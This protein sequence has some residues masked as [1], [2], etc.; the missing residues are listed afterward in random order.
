MGKMGTLAE[1]E[2][3]LNGVAAGAPQT[4]SK[5]T[6]PA[7]PIPRIIINH[8]EASRGLAA[9][10]CLPL[11]K[12]K[13]GAGEINDFSILGQ[14]RSQ[15]TR[16]QL[17]A[18]GT[19]MA[20]K[21]WLIL[22]LA[23]LILAGLAC[24]QRKPFLSWYYVRQLV[25]ADKENRATWIKRVADLNQTVL[26]RL[27]SCLEYPEE[28]A[29]DNITAALVCLVELWGPEDERSVALVEEL[30]QNLLRYSQA[31][32]Q[33]SLQIPAVLLRLSQSRTPEPR[34][35]KAAGDLLTATARNAELRR[36]TLTLGAALVKHSSRGPISQTCR[37]LGLSGL[38]DPSPENRVRAVNLVLRVG[39]PQLLCKV[40]PL[41]KDQAAEVRQAAVTALGPAKESLG[42]DDLLPLLHDADPGVRKLTEEALRSRGLPE[43]HVLLARLISDDRPGERLQVVHHLFQTEDLPVGIWLRRL[44][45]DPAPAVRAAAV[46]AAHY[47]TKADLRDRLL[48]MAREDPSATV[49]QLASHYLNQPSI[50][51]EEN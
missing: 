46:R 29:C 23:L 13:S 15:L 7:S 17:S 27:L 16:N 37:D 1:A 19:F 8:P 45:Q 32:K 39:E 6:I 41:L 51:I 49:R 35:V 26:P 20:R 24:W 44:S 18:I 43:S 34:L 38:K 40:V 5:S 31:G 21:K 36:G 25:H 2:E 28:Q 3:R 33:S 9:S 14:V 22:L 30:G 11:F 50:R 12:S 4:P 42:D 47:Q 10:T 48:E